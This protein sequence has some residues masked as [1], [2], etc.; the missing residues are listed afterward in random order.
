MAGELTSISLAMGMGIVDTTIKGLY[1]FTASNLGP[2]INGIQ[3]VLAG[4]GDARL[5]GGGDSTMLGYGAG[6]G[7]TAEASAYR[8]SIPSYL[9]DYLAQK[10]VNSNYSGRM[11]DGARGNA[12]SQI[13]DSRISFPAS[14]GVL[15]GATVLG[16]QWFQNTTT[17]DIFTI[18]P[19]QPVNAGRLWY[20]RQSGFAQGRLQHGAGSV[21]PLNEAGASLVA[22]IGF[23]TGNAADLSPLSINRLNTSTAGSQFNIGGWEFWDTAKKQVIV[24]NIAMF[25]SAAAQWAAN[26]QYRYPAQAIKVLAYNGLL[27]NPGINDMT[28]GVSVSTF[29]AQMQIIIDAQKTVGSIILLSPFPVNPTIIPQSLQDQYEQAYRDL[30]SAND[31]PLVVTREI[32]GA[33][34]PT[35]WYDDKHPKEQIYRVVGEATAQGILKASGLP[36]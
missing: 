27:L 6:E 29:M 17:E 33:W 18:T 32:V 23:S 28:Q 31:T 12:N 21:I 24:S 22:S 7:G 2:L 26:S 11:G 16:S 9:S 19:N 3:A 30:S 25:G 34:S 10:S 5:A 35:A 1:N 13:F 36:F 14:W 4:T 20:Y 8:H 15:A